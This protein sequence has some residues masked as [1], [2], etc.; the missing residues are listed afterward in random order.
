MGY[1]EGFFKYSDECAFLVKKLY[2]KNFSTK[3]LQVRTW[4]YS[5]LLPLFPLHKKKKNTRGYKKEHDVQPTEI[6]LK[7]S[8]YLNRHRDMKAGGIFARI[9][10]L[11]TRRMWMISFTPR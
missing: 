7:L 6:N 5:K 3:L 4:R 2:L 11:N 10:N 1:C 8:L 9:L